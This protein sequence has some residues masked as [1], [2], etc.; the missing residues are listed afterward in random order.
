[1]V[2]SQKATTFEEFVQWIENARKITTS[3]HSIERFNES[4]LH[5]LG[6]HFE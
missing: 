6:K 5:A 4:S 3:K 2:I 1:V